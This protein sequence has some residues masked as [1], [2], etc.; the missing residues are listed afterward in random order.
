MISAVLEYPQWREGERWQVAIVMSPRIDNAGRL[1]LESLAEFVNA[2]EHD[3]ETFWDLADAERERFRLGDST[4][5]TVNLRE[6]AAVDAELRSVSAVNDYLR[7]LTAYEQVT[8]RAL[9]TP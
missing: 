8:A 4:L 1:Q 6:Q 7:A 2:I 9:A 5:F 3:A